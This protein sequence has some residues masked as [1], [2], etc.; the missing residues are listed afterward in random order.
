MAFNDTNDLQVEK[1]I[2]VRVPQ[3]TPGQ[4]PFSAGRACPNFSLTWRVIAAELLT[5][6]GA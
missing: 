1:V 6:V 4:N 2:P 5:M 3:P